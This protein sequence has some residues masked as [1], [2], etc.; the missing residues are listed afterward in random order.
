MIYQTFEFNE[1][2]QKVWAEL[3]KIYPAHLVSFDFDNKIFIPEND[4]NLANE[5]ADKLNEIVKAHGIRIVWKDQN[6]KEVK[7]DGII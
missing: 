5:Y 6:G 7:N 4:L 3:S 2:G 1:E